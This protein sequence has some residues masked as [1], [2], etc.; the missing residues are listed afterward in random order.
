MHRMRL[1]FSITL[2]VALLG[3][4][5]HGASADPVDDA[6]AALE[7]GRPCEAMRLLEEGRDLG[8]SAPKLLGVAESEC[9]AEEARQQEEETRQREAE[10]RDGRREERRERR[11][12]E[13]EREREADGEVPATP[14][15][16]ADASREANDLIRVARGAALRGE[17]AE[18]VRLLIEARELNPSEPTV[19]LLLY[20]NYSRLGNNREAS[21]AL[22]QYLMRAPH[23]PNAGQYREIIERLE[24]D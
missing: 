21:R 6:R 2:A 12:Q 9:A 22:R 20:T 17:H 19:Y 3:G 4:F 16:S 24:G 5:L 11:E 14:P 13:R 1:A 18:T 23:D 8:F 7:A 15:A 10:R